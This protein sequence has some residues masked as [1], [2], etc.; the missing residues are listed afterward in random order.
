MLFDFPLDDLPDDDLPVVD[1]PVD[2]LLMDALRGT[3]GIV[4]TGASVG[5]ACIKGTA[6]MPG[7]GNGPWFESILGQELGGGGMAIGNVS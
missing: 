3:A 4:G 5:G 7:S 1:L 6:G 2:A